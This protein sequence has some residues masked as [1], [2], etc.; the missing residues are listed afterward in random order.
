MS[1]VPICTYLD[2]HGI[3][4]IPIH[5]PIDATGKKG[6]PSLPF[7]LGPIQPYTHFPSTVT[8]EQIK[9]VQAHTSECKFIAMDTRK[10]H[11][12]DVDEMN[13]EMETF[14]NDYPHFLS[15][16]KKLPHIFY[17][18]NEEPKSN[19]GCFNG[20]KTI[21]LLTGQWSYAPI[22]AMVINA[23]KPMAHMPNTSPHVDEPNIPDD[24]KHMTYYQKAIQRL[25]PHHSKTQV[26]S[27][28]ATTGAIIT[29]GHYCENV[30]RAHKSNHVFFK[31]RDGC[32]FQKCT[33]PEC[34]GFEG[35][36]YPLGET[37]A[38]DVEFSDQTAFDEVMKKYSNMFKRHNKYPLAFDETT[39]GGGGCGRAA[40]AAV[41]RAGVVGG[42][43]AA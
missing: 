18:A 40:A 6:A 16:T 1:N 29:N 8:D 30:G 26:K 36:M 41:R 15:S 12:I 23:D 17:T 31:V 3:R 19:R 39:G 43:R 34:E 27:I 32:I 22:D 25:V 37:K 13:E 38:K 10:V 33:D 20:M 5:I 2:T 7:G 21:E 28:K 4:W 35:T 11:Q 24:T 9:S 42:G 14:A